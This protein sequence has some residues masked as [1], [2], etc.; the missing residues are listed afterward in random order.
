MFDLETAISEW[1]KRLVA[2]GLKS[3]NALDELES[4]LRDD[5]EELVRSGKAVE[6]AFEL[7]VVRI[8]QSVVLAEEFSKVLP[9]RRHRPKYLMG[10]SLMSAGLIFWSATWILVETGVSSVAEGLVFLAVYL[11]TAYL[12]ALPFCYHRLPSL[13]NPAV[14]KAITVASLLANLWIVLALLSALGKVQIHLPETLVMLFWSI[15]PALMATIL[16]Y[17]TYNLS[18][19]RARAAAVLECLTPETQRTLDVARD[20]ARS[21]H[22][23]FIGTE[24]VLLALLQSGSPGIARVMKRFGLEA[25]AVRA[26]IERIVATWSPATRGNEIPYTP[27]AIRALDLAAREAHA[28]GGTAAGLEHIFL[29][30][31]IEDGGVAGLVLR[32]LGVNADR[33]RAEIL[34]GIDPGDGEGPEQVLA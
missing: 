16:A 13:Q 1:R 22:H 8:G 25:A 23:D 6:N 21:F 30:L 9:E 28:M 2:T 12:A 31:I 29:G 33:V 24:H 4:H 20:E 3:R 11:V 34:K 19:K 14:Q 15:V 17:D 10:F 18:R 27:R 32:N 26:E 5:I 7:A